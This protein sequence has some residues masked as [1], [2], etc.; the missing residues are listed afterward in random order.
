LSI[1]MTILSSKI[2]FYMYIDTCIN[3]IENYIVA[4]E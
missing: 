1:F 2:S 3:T 4:T